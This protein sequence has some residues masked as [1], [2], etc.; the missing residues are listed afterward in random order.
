LQVRVLH[1]PPKV[2]NGKASG[3]RALVVAL[4]LKVTA[5]NPSF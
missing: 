1:G 2:I 3:K 4:L 5:I